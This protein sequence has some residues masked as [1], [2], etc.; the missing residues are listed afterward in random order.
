MAYR[1]LERQGSP[2]QVRSRAVDAQG[3][4]ATDLGCKDTVLVWPGETVSLSIDFG[5]PNYLSQQIFLFHCHNLEH[6]DKGMMLK[7]RLDSPVRAQWV[8]KLRETIGS[9]DLKVLSV[10]F[11]PWFACLTPE[12]GTAP[13]P[14]WKMALIVLLGLYPTV[15][16]LTLF[17]GPYVSPLGLALAMLIGNALSISI[18]QWAVMPALNHLFSGWLLANTPAQWVLSVSGSAVILGLLAVLAL[19]FRQVTG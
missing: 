8:E 14:G 10:G 16:V 17:P 4:L 6:E 5:S 2:S 13:P 9:F 11:G 19:L 7:V 18:L 15:M 3:R 1:V 12:A